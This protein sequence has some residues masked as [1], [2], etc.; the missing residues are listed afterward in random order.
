MINSTHT[1]PHP[2]A[3]QAVEIDVTGVG[4]GTYTVEDWWDRASGGSWMYAESKPAALK[5]AVRGGISGLPLDDEV[6]YGKL[7]GLGHLLHVSELP[8]AT[9][10]GGERS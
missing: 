4:T 5:Y 10:A 7:D 9:E 1:D 8:V 3:R 6:V 2:L